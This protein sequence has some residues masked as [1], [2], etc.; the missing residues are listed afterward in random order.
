M[1]HYYFGITVEPVC[2]EI[3]KFEKFT[4]LKVF[5][6]YWKCEFKYFC[7]LAGT[8]INYVTCQAEGG[9][10]RFVIKWGELVL[11]AATPQEHLTKIYFFLKLPKNPI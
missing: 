7:V 4:H 9:A 8:F 11:I 10:M 3:L 5:E 6:K 2:M 1:H